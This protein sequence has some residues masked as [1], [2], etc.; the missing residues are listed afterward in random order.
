MLR[1]MRTMTIT[2]KRQATL[3]AALCHELGL[4]PGG[5]RSTW[6]AAWWMGRPCGCAGAADSTGRGSGLRVST[7][8][9][10]GTGGRESRRSIERG[11]AGHDRA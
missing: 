8:R 7:V 10:T 9:A 6:I 2:S 4:R 1:T 3:P 5:G 11:W